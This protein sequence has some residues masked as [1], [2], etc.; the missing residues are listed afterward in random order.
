MEKLSYGKWYLR[1]VRTLSEHSFDDLTAK[2]CN[3]QN[4]KQLNFWITPFM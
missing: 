3:N 4:L 2:L 1:N